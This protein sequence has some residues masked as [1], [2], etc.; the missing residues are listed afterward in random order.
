MVTA[1]DC[2]GSLS[3]ALS[4]PAPPPRRRRWRGRCR[5]RPWS[6]RN[7][8]CPDHPGRQL[9]AGQLQRHQ[10]QGE[11]HADEGEHRGGDDPQDI[12][13]RRRIDPQPLGQ[14]DGMPRRSASAVRTASTTPAS[15]SSD[16]RTQNRS[17]SHSRARTSKYPPRPGPKRTDRCR[18][19]LRIVSR[20]WCGFSR[21]R[22]L[23]SPDP[24]KADPSLTSERHC[25]ALPR[26]RSGGHPRLCP[27]PKSRR[28]GRSCIGTGAWGDA[29]EV[30]PTKVDDH[31]CPSAVARPT[32]PATCSVIPVRQARALAGPHHP[33]GVMLAWPPHR[34]MRATTPDGK[35]MGR[36]QRR[37][38]MAGPRRR[39]WTS[40]AG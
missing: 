37:H 27:V 9:G 21:P 10:R 31:P 29:L 15:T 22:Q 8:Q 35:R 17:C 32:P 7:G 12:A 40:F 20:W 1:R 24:N 16:G 23:I 26:H 13:G 34:T 5:R 2:A 28:P 38:A 39:R 25:R 19:H 6:P 4:A 3:R 36:G 14:L 30:G 11:D 18:L 33:F